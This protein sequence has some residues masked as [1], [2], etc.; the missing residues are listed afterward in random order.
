MRKALCL[1]VGLIALAVIPTAALAGVVGSVHDLPAFYT[2]LTGT[3]AKQGTCS[4]CHVPH[5]AQT[6]GDR[7]FPLPYAANLPVTWSSDSLSN[8]CWFCHGAGSGYASAIEV[9][10][11]QGTSH[12]RESSWLNRTGGITGHDP[13]DI[14]TVPSDMNM[15][16]TQLRCVSCHK[17]HDNTLKPFL[18]WGVS[19]NFAATATG[20]CGKCHPSRSNVNSYGS[21]NPGNHPSAS[22]YGDVGGGGS[23]VVGTALPTRMQVD[24]VQLSNALSGAWN[25][26]GHGQWAGGTEN[27]AQMVCG[28][29]HAVH[30]NE[31]TTWDAGDGGTAVPTAITVAGTPILVDKDTATLATEQSAPICVDCH[32]IAFGTA[33]RG[34]GAVG[35]YS[36]PVGSTST[37]ANL[38]FNAGEGYKWNTATT[39]YTIVCQSCHDIHW[40]ETNHTT[41][42]STSSADFLVAYQCSECH[43]VG[44]T[45]FINHHPSNIASP[46]TVPGA[47]TSSATDW[48][49]RTQTK[50]GVPYFPAGYTALTCNTCHGLGLGKAHNNSSGFPGLTG[51]NSESDMCV[52]CH[53]FNPSLYTASNGTGTGSPLGTH[54]VGAMTATTYRKTTVFVTGQA[55]QTA[56]YAPDGTN[57]SIICESCHTAK[58]EGRNGHAIRY[59]DSDNRNDGQAG[60]RESVVLML[61]V[62]GNRQGTAY[63]NVPFNNADD[64]LCTACHGGAPGGG[65]T[66]PVLPSYTASATGNV[67]ITAPATAAANASATAGQINCESCHRAHDAATGSLGT[68]ANAWVPAWILE[69]GSYDATRNYNDFSPVCG[70]CHPSQH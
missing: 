14:G 10:P 68:S 6:G 57:N 33:T 4:F 65:L 44:A 60:T 50:T 63:A 24:M 47:N 32:S 45:T 38:M 61:Q 46:V 15:T 26:G 18:S 55:N 30:S 31:T 51:V 37:W 3:S 28:S 7:L 41:A 21:L 42:G 58:M 19:G 40:S 35:T 69:A 43:S 5:K 8:I 39:P 66:H 25:L 34:P 17:I 67:T 27:A 48:S 23:P 49:A 2:T 13:G 70:L 59:R 20:F 12:L 64:N 11:F 22:T 9:N 54:F 16:G 62:S 52:D 1:A 56:K 36:H 53:G 29:C